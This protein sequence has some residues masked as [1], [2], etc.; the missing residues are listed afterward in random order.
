MRSPV[1]FYPGC[2]LSLRRGINP[3]DALAWALKSAPTCP[4][5]GA[6][7]ESDYEPE[8]QSPAIIVTFR[9]LN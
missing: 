5:A 1:G 6:P 4:Q 9:L 7:L 8:A 2:A 3:S